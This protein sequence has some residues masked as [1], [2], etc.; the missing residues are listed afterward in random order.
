[1]A[2]TVVQLP[3]ANAS[4]AE[5]R[6]AILPEDVESFDE[7]FQATLDAAAR[8]RRLDKLEPFLGGCCVVRSWGR[9]DR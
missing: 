9:R 2:A 6:E 1:M 3:Y 7:Q 5:L 4:P 8:T